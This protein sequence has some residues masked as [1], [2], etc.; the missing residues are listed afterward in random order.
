MYDLPVD[1]HVRL[2]VYNALGQKVTALIDEYQ[3]A[4]SKVF[5]WNAAGSRYTSGIYFY[6]LQAG[7]FTDVKKMVLLK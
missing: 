2:E 7:D 1:C 6:R 4:G 5:Y 3:T